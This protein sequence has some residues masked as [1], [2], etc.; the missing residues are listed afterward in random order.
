RNHIAQC[1]DVSELSIT[2]VMWKQ[3]EIRA[4][5]LHES[6]RPR[7]A[8]HE[9]LRA[10][11]AKQMPKLL[12]RRTPDPRDV[13]PQPGLLLPCESPVHFLDQRAPRTR[14]DH[15]NAIIR[16]HDRANGRAG[17]ITCSVHPV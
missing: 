5:C 3:L 2:Q 17:Q 1:R 6:Q 10:D 13:P 11:G 15:A 16:A 7:T 12:L 9:A 8:E 4:W 14:H